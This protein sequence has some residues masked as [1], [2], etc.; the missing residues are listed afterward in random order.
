MPVRAPYCSECLHSC[1]PYESS[2]MG[3][4]Q[5]SNCCDE[6]VIFC[7]PNEIGTIRRDEFMPAE[8]D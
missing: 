4:V 3:G 7:T 6:S 1:R 5:F 8:E 2:L